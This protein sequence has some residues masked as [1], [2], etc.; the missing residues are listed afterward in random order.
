MILM[1]KKFE[2]LD[3]TPGDVAFVAYGEDLESTFANAALATFEVMVDTKDVDDKK[4]EDIEVRGHDLMSLMFNWLSELIY[5]SSTKNMMFSKFDVVIKK[6]KMLLKAKCY[7]DKI[8]PKKH[9]LK[10]EVKAVTYHQMDVSRTNGGWKSQV[11][12]DL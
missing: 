7:G 3:I 9:A 6:D 4:E 1:T 8:K 11:I 10:T 5:T 12:L 2:F